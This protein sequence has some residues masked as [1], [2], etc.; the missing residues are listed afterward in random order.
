MELDAEEFNRQSLDSILTW[1]LYNL[2]ILYFLVTQLA[3]DQFQ[4]GV[5]WLKVRLGF[6][7]V[8]SCYI[9]ERGKSIDMSL[10]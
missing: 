3:Y 9:R 1:L 10:V 7:F 5:G 4:W 6:N 8:P 2:L